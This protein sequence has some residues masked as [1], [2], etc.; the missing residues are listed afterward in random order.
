MIC[1]YGFFYALACGSAQACGSKE[2]SWRVDRGSI[3]FQC[4]TIW[5]AT[6]WSKINHC[7]GPA[8]DLPTTLRALASGDTKQREH[9]LWEL[10]GNIWH[11]GTV[12]EATAYAVP[13]LLELVRN[14]HADTLEVLGLLALIADGNSY[15]KVHG[16]DS[17]MSDGEYQAQLARELEWVAEAKKAVAMGSELFMELLAAEDRKLREMAAFLLGLTRSVA[18]RPM[19]SAQ[20][21]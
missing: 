20:W 18:P 7:Y 3:I 14:N 15:L 13:F 2:F 12:Y 6:D 1:R 9:A 8:T 21:K 5:T 19:T 17:K 11:Q 16:K 4:P 10:H